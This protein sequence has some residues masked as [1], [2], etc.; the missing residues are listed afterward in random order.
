M[1][2]E[3]YVRTFRFLDDKEGDDGYADSV[4]HKPIAYVA[5]GDPRLT[6]RPGYAKTNGEVPLAGLLILRRQGR[7]IFRY[8]KFCLDVK[9]KTRDESCVLIVLRICSSCLAIKK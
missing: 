2:S 1:G 6:W 4:R 8:L 3:N 9:K 7:E 5:S